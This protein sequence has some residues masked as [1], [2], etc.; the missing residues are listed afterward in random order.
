MYVIDA[1]ESLPSYEE[2]AGYLATSIEEVQTN[3]KIFGLL[4]NNIHFV[5]ELFSNSLPI[6]REQHDVPIAVLRVDGNFYDSHQDAMYYLYDKVPL[7]DIVIFDDI[8]TQ[9]GAKEFG[10]T[11]SRI[12]N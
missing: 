2:N 5:K 3:F 7:G 10:R 4:N 9:A 11:S 12:M 8:W 6:L 1:F